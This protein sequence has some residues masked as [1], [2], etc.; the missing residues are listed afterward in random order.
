LTDQAKF[1]ICDHT[2]EQDH[3][4]IKR[5]ISPGLG[6]DSFWTARRTFRGYEAMHMLQKG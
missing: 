3:W 6:F 5:H 4:F 2:I 1:V